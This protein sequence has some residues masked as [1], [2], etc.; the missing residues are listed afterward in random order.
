[1]ARICKA[2]NGPVCPT[3]GGCIQEGECICILES[4]TVQELQQQRD[5][6][7]TACEQV[8]AWLA[9]SPEF[10]DWPA[11]WSYRSQLERAISTVKGDPFQ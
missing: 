9:I 4:P 7:L 5:E 8:A 1:M 2:C 11:A 3:C 6:L 10:Q